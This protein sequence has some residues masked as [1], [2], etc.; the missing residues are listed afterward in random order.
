MLKKLLSNKGKVI[1]SLIILNII[2]VVLGINSFNQINESSKIANQIYQGPLH[3]INYARALQKD[4]LLIQLHLNKLAYEDDIDIQEN[5]KSLKQFHESFQEDIIVISEYKT[6]DTSII[7]NKINEH[8]A[9]WWQ[10]GGNF[11]SL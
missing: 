4:F 5:I 11:S 7:I 10:H 6:E 9:T 8:M 2:I 1:T 3:S